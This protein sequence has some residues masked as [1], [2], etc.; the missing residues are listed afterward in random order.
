[1]NIAEEF[2]ERLKHVKDQ[3]G[4]HAKGLLDDEG[5]HYGAYEGLKEKYLTEDLDIRTR[6]EV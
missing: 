2:V 6:A 5:Y 1:M 3:K 4:I